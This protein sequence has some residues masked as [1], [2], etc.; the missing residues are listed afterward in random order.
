LITIRP[1]EPGDAV[2]VFRINER[3]FGRPDE[4]RLVEALRV[5]GAATLS[6]VAEKE[7]DIVGH[8]LFSPVVITSSAGVFTATGLAPMAVTPSQQRLGIG[9]TLVEEG[10]DRLRRA[11]HGLVIVLGH[12]DYYPRFG[13][14][15]ASRYGLR[16][17]HEAP[18]DA[19]MAMELVP[20]W[21]GG[22]TGIV[23]YRPEFDGV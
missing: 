19:F 11:G 14:V 6:L 21:L 8:I 4:A 20:G 9:S 22:R 3:A 1:E 2:A 17:E 10:L 5:A 15:P 18:D 23:S 16:W 12:H 13:F 7:G